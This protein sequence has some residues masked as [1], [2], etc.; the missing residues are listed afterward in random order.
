MKFRYLALVFLLG[1]TGNKAVSDVYYIPEGAITD[2]SG[3]DLGR[4]DWGRDQGAEDVVDDKDSLD[5]IEPGDNTAE[6]ADSDTSVDPDTPVPDDGAITDDLVEDDDGG[7]VGPAA[8][9]VVN[10]ALIDFGFVQNGKYG[11]ARF[12]IKNNSLEVDLQVN[13][14]KIS[15]SLQVALQ[16]EEEP[17]ITGNT[18][19]YTLKKPIVIPPGETMEFTLRFTPTADASMDAELEIYSSDPKYPDGIKIFVIGNRNR[20]CIRVNPEQIDFRLVS[21]GAVIDLPIKI[22]SCGALPL[23]IT[24][25]SLTEDAGDVGLSLDFKDF[26]GQAAPTTANPVVISSGGREHFVLRYAPTEPS[27]VGRDGRPIGLRELL[28]I[29]S[30]GFNGGAYLPIS[31]AAIDRPCAV[32]VIEADLEG[33]LFVGDI[34]RL[35]ALGSMSPFSQV[36]SWTWV[37]NGPDNGP[38]VVL[39]FPDVPEVML[40]L[41]GPGQY[42]VLLTVDDTDGHG[43][44][45]SAIRKFTAIPTNKAMIA[46]SWRPVLG[47]AVPGDGPDADLHLLHPRANAD[48]WFDTTWDCYWGNQWPLKSEWGVSDPSIDDTVEMLQFSED[49]TQSEIIKLGMYCKGNTVYRLGVH[50]YNDHEFGR[51]E[52][53]VRIWDGLGGGATIA[54]QLSHNDLWELATFACPSGAIV[55]TNPPIIIRDYLD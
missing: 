47:V 52:A 18:R 43:S 28:A 30:S 10:P 15:G 13:R 16:I 24:D 39:P 55:E 33:D 36:D 42:E 2:L 54:H 19:D 37:V 7:P 14:F 3:L 46:L 53:V 4:P 41:G 34:V 44:C 32:P 20:A 40:P 31:G 48:G 6:T 45:S 12:F 8:E 50:V 23:Q 35:S 49:G 26:P 11:N 29:T 22:E 9:M 21:V 25:I 1:C 27:E 5:L 51:I 17:K 38:A